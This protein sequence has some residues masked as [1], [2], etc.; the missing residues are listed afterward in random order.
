[1]AIG[2]NPPSTQ[3]SNGCS[4][5]NKRTIRQP[6]F[7]G[8]ISNKPWQARLFVLYVPWHVPIQIWANPLCRSQEES[9]ITFIHF[10]KHQ[11]DQN[12]WPPTAGPVAH[13]H[14]PHC[15]LSSLGTFALPRRIPKQSC[16][17]KRL[18]AQDLE[19][20]FH[21][22][23]S[24]CVKQAMKKKRGLWRLNGV[25]RQTYN[26]TWLKFERSETNI[27]KRKLRWEM[28]YNSHKPTKHH[29]HQQK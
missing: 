16:S 1:M 18:L 14:S 8:N 6:C 28:E 29:C 23:T 9:P 10:G 26:F 25:W 19:G 11:M 27:Q 5:I 21:P 24:E 22:S 7:M 3:E 15:S 20:P 4:F 13:P 17:P 12:P 2:Y